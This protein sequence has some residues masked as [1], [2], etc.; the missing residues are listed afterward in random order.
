MLDKNGSIV[1]NIIN[2]ISDGAYKIIDADDIISA[3]PDGVKLTR[4]ELSGI[5]RSLVDH[6]LIAVKYS[7]LEEY[8]LAALP[9]ARIIAEKEREKAVVPPPPSVYHNNSSSDGGEDDDETEN[10]DS[11]Y[12]EGLVSQRM[13]TIDYSLIRKNAKSGAF[14]GA[15]F[16][17]FIAGLFCIA[18]LLLL[19]N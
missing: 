8:C 11:V 2:G 9:K 17:S 5:I 3:V 15:F 18:L 4:L 6:E 14:V 13:S 19:Y 12:N 7:N 16:G 10:K 1:L